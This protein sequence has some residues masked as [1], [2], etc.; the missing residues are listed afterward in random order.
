MYRSY[1]H[2]KKIRGACASKADLLNLLVFY[3]ELI[4]LQWKRHLPY[5]EHTLTKNY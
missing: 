3:C 4:D 5:A 2:K 1:F